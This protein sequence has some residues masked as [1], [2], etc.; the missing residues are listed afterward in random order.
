[1]GFRTCSKRQ[2]DATDG[3]PPMIQPDPTHPAFLKRLQR[4]PYP[5]LSDVPDLDDGTSVPVI[6]QIDEIAR[7]E[8]RRPGDQLQPVMPF[9][10]LCETIRRNP[11]SWR[12][13]LDG[14][15]VE[16]FIHVQPITKS[17]GDALTAGMIHENDIRPRHVCAPGKIGKGSYIHIGC[18]AA[19]KHPVQVT[20]D[21]PIRLV[22][23]VIDRV[24]ELR[25]EQPHIRRVIATD[26][27]DA[28]GDHHFG[29]R[30]PRYGFTR[31]AK[32]S[33]GDTVYVLD[34]EHEP[35]A[36]GDLLRVV[37]TRRGK[38]GRKLE[39]RI[40]R[41]GILM[42]LNTVADRLLQLAG[43]LVGLFRTK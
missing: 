42:K 17:A 19:R 31:V 16:G 29:A 11:E 14:G 38:H 18:V 7:S 12:I 23:G 22:A 5:F 9:G 26:S 13:L 33:T 20:D 40:R 21:T 43:S 37:S 8:F 10:Q 25:H 4:L 34:L 27:P 3:D 24:L 28:S 30:L 2:E 41:T 36:F 35:R 6:A 15:S 39:A 1:V 32:T